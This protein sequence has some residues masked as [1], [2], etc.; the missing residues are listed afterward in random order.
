MAKRHWGRKTERQGE[1]R[2]GAE[3]Q[4]KKRKN[5]WRQ[6]EREKGIR[7]TEQ[8]KIETGREEERYE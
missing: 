2:H 8:R 7:K 6:S 1:V 3:G 5:E 4:S